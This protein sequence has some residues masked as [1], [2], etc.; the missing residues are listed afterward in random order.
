MELRDCL[1]DCTDAFNLVCKGIIAER[2]MEYNQLIAW[3]KSKLSGLTNVEEEEEMTLSSTASLPLIPQPQTPKEPMEFLSRSWSISAEEIS[4]ALA[5]KQKHSL[6]ERHP[7][8]S[9][10]ETVASPPHVVER[11]TGSFNSRRMG[12]IGK[13]FNHKDSNHY[14][15]MKKKDR[16]RA[17]NAHMHAAL[18]IAGLAAALAAVSA[19]EDSSSGSKMSRALASATELLASRCI[20]MAEHAG[21]D[22]ERVASS[23]SSAV[24][25]KSPGD[26]MTLTAA[27]AT[28]LRAEAALRSRLP[29]EPKRNATISPCDRSL[30]DGECVDPLLVQIEEP[31]TTCVGDL[32]QHTRKGALR[33]KRISIYINKK[34]QVMIKSKSKHV[35]GAFSKKDKCLVYGVSDQISACP[36]KRKGENMDAYFGLRTGQGFLEFKCKNKIH[37]QQ[38]VDGIQSLLSQACDAEG[39]IEHS[40]GSMDLNKRH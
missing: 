14:G 24:D 4:K 3:N 20:E 15:S 12:G 40:F 22:H 8:T 17:E 16:A 31:S 13:W 38:W 25:V 33:W 35:G 18:S 26:L 36:F 27:A 2:I 9:I 29:K 19:G 34:S 39:S 1:H 5:N 32:L 7:I 21:A 30:T 28:A 37:K 23:V 10:P 6:L 11:V